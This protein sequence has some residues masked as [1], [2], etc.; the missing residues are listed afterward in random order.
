MIYLLLFYQ[1]F[2]QAVLHAP[3]QFTCTLFSRKQSHRQVHRPLGARRSI[4][5]LRGC[6]RTHGHGD[7]YSGAHENC[8]GCLLS[9]Y[10][11]GSNYAHTHFVML[12]M[13]V[14]FMGSD[15]QADVGAFYVDV[16]QG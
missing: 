2:F 9:S 11:K 15:P 4:S 12:H 8:L 7:S 6:R 1:D 3:P 13:V 5:S 16:L 14:D 10:A